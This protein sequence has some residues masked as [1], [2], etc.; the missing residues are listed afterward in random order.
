MPSLSFIFGAIL[1]VI[2]SFGAGFTTGDHHRGV[3]DKKDQVIEI[4]KGND[5]ARAA[6][7]Q[8][9]AK[10]NKI[11]KNTLG[12]KNAIEQKRNQYLADLNPAIGLRPSGGAIPA[13]AETSFGIGG[14]A[15]RLSG[16]DAIYLKQILTNFAAE[17]SISEAERNEVIL[18]YEALP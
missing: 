4:A 10:Q 18:K 9:G 12:E 1:A 15:L 14:Q 3:V 8:T 5:G 16:Q 11:E 13:G 6:E 2:L 17:C 7:H